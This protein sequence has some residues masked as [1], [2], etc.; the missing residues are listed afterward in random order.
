MTKWA[1]DVFQTTPGQ[2]REDLNVY[3]AGGCELVNTHHSLFK[4]LCVI[5]KPLDERDAS[6]EVKTNKDFRKMREMYEKG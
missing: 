6:G 5:K 2:L 3:G 4:V 1:Y